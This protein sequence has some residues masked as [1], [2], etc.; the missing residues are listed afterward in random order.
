MLSWI[1]VFFF[2]KVNYRNNSDLK[3]VE[4][5][6]NSHFGQSIVYLNIHMYIYLIFLRALH[7]KK[8]AV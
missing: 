2:F 6:F 8:K 4:F 1:I 3:F 7:K 5:I